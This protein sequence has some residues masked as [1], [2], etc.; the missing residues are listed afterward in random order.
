MSNFRLTDES[1]HQEEII[2]WCRNHTGSYPELELLY[3]VPNGGKR[4][5][6]TAR[7]LKRQG[8][9]AGVPD[10][11]L[12]VSRCGFHG[13]YIELKAPGGKMEQSQI[14]YL[15]SVEQQAYLALVCVGW[16]A[17]VQALKDYP[18]GKEPKTEH[19]KTKSTSKE[20]TYRLVYTKSIERRCEYESQT[21][22]K[23]IQKEIWS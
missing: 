17:A 13:L 19:L 16:R 7:V 11:V 4:D 23:S 14:D 6:D 2:S 1:G 9:K 20:G 21:E 5:R 3:H 10:L 18:E 15:Q 22:E 8:V 12:P